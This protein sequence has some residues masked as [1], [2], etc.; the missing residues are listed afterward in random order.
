MCI[1]D[2]QK[3]D[4]ERIYGVKIWDLEV[5]WRYL[6]N[7]LLPSSEPKGS[8]Q[9]GSEQKNTLYIVSIEVV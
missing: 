4:P 3:A 7:A 9:K 2:S 5:K 6:S 8:E 1:R